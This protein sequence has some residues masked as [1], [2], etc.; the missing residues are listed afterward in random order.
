MTLFIDRWLNTS[1]EQLL[2]NHHLTN[3]SVMAVGI[4][5]FRYI[6]DKFNFWLL[7]II[8]LYF[9]TKMIIITLNCRNNLM[10]I[11]ILTLLI[12]TSFSYFS[13]CESEDHNPKL[14]FEQ[15]KRAKVTDIEIGDDRIG[16]EEW[17]I[18][19]EATLVWPISGN[20]YAV[21]E[22]HCRLNLL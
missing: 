7:S 20:V 8:A 3:I 16:D 1:L 21:C 5:F 22:D 4:H 19:T 6:H 10:W 14:D 9:Y 13:G 15:L 18:I 11:H 17:N 12:L 2:S